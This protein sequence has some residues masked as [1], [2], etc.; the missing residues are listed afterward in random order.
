MSHYSTIFIPHLSDG[1]DSLGMLLP[2][3]AVSW[4]DMAELTAASVHPKS[5]LDPVTLE[6]K[7]ASCFHSL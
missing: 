6:L 5:G 1:R 7:N 2:G 4:P 3:K